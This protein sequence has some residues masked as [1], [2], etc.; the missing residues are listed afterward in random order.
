MTG[1]LLVL[2]LLPGGLGVVPPLPLPSPAVVQPAAADALERQA[3]RALASGDLREAVRLYR[4]LRTSWPKAPAAAD[5]Y[6]WEAFALFRQGTATALREART[7]LTLQRERFPKAASREDAAALETRI[8]GALAR[9]GD[10]PSA[11]AIASKADAAD[12]PAPAGRPTGCDAEGTEERVAALNALLQ[13]DG[14]RALPILEKVLARRDACSLTLR[15]KAV[16]LVS[17]K[18]GPDASALLIQA[19]K[20]DPDPEVREQAVFWLGQ[21]GGE[22]AVTVLSDLVRVAKDRGM[23]EKALFALAQTG[24]PRASAAL[25]T[26]AAD[27]GADPALRKS[28]IFWMGQQSGAREGWVQALVALYRSLGD[29]ALRD[30]VLFSL[31]QARSAE[32]LAFLRDVA[33]NPEERDARREQAVFWYAQ[34]GGSVDELMAIYRTAASTDLREKVIFALSQR[35]RDA[36]AVDQLLAIARNEKDRAL[37]KSAIFWLSQSRDPRVTEFL[38]ELVD[39]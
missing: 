32:A 13:M 8:E 20:G 39:R 6:Y 33:R 15:R 26:V 21:S 29:D 2:L 25:R 28:A 4:E 34:G 24:H 11:V 23:R 1:S 10:V 17:Q 16:F 19:I 36:K 38:Q 37:R 18:G 14:D 22:D 27:E 31:S 3:R 7:A 35:G 5:A 30:Q 9:Q 12:R